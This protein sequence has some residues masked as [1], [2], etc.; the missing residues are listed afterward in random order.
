MLLAPLPYRGG[1][2]PGGRQEVGRDRRPGRLGYLT[3]LDLRARSRSFEGL[4]AASQRLGHPRGGREGRRARQRHAGVGG[5]LRDPRAAARDRA[6]RSPRAKT[7][8]APRVGWSSSATR[9]GVA[10]LAAIPRSSA[11]PSTW[12]ARPTWWSGSCPGCCDDLVAERMFGGAELYV[13]ARVR[14]RRRFACRTCRHLRLRPPGAG[15]H[16]R[17]SAGR[18][19]HGILRGPRPR[20]IPTEYDVSRAPSVVTLA[21]IC[22]SDRSARCCSR[23]AGVLLLLLV[24]LRQRLESAAA[25]R[26]RAR[27]RDLGPHR[28]RRDSRA[29]GPAARHG[30]PAPGARGWR[31][32][33]VAGLGR[34]AARGRPRSRAV[35]AAGRR[36]PR[37]PGRRR[38]PGPG[39]PVRAGLW[40]RAARAALAQGRRPAPLHGGGRHTGDRHGLA[41]AVV[42]GRRQRRRRASCCSSARACSRRAC[43]GSCRGA[44]LRARTDADRCSSA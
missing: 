24:G 41:R 37:R 23:S 3:F 12:P 31:S 29:P 20:S 42:P 8:P 7:G 4:V 6:A 34:A 17:E 26:S 40:S 1:R 33:L 30:V 10:A 2:S 11:G 21:E 19:L 14:P 16:G 43:P 9:C 32:G 13:P 18:D 35:A 27:A 5:L 25:A 44:G 39:G 15:R 36:D 28:A 22:G 38:G